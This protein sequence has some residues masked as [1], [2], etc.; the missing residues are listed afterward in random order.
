MQSWHTKLLRSRI[1][2]A[3]SGMRAFRIHFG[4]VEVV[5]TRLEALSHQILR[6][7]A[8][9]DH[10]VITDQTVTPSRIRLTSVRQ[11]HIVV[12]RSETHLVDVHLIVEAHP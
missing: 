11:H 8:V 7:H 3:V 1:A 12:L 6:L 5:D 9:Q 10:S 2:G 4:V